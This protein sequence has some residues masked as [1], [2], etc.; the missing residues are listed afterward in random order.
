LENIEVLI[1]V[2]GKGAR[3]Q[4]VV[5]DVPKPMA[6]IGD[7]PFLDYLIENLEN[8]GLCNISLLSGYK[9]ELIADHFKAKKNVKVIVEDKPLGTG[10]AIINALKEVEGE[11][12]LVLNGD[13][14]FHG[15]HTPLLTTYHKDRFLMGLT[16]VEDVSRYGEV[17]LNESNQV[18][19]MKEKQES[20]SSGLINLGM[21]L[22]NKE[23]LSS[24]ST[25]EKSSLETEILPKLIASG[26]VF[27]QALK[28]D[29]IDIGIP[30]D[31]QKSQELIP[32]WL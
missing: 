1:L 21:Y 15:A 16:L 24:F 20:S 11:R 2:G 10:G 25:L 18:E 23:V 17:F 4:S 12:I 19:K 27:G 31:Y 7:R 26:H 9:A 28:G 29:F 14:F 22:F 5:S 8:Q 13:T 32:R 30:S 3:L 6:P